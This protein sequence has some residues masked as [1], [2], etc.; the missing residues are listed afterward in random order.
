MNECFGIDEGIKERYY[1]VI[2]V[3]VDENCLFS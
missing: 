1:I 3:L 2:E